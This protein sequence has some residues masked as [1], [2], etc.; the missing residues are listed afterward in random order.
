[1]RSILVIIAFLCLLAACT[2]TNE[3]VILLQAK[4][5]ELCTKD[6]ISFRDHIAPLVSQ[7]CMP[8]HSA[9]R[10]EGGI[11]L[12]NYSEISGLASSGVLM[13]VIKHDPGFAAMPKNEPKIP[14]CEIRAFQVWVDQGT[15]NN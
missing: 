6:T 8:C 4:Q 1:M 7:R 12:E 9:A 13:G 14:E 3:Q 15:L 11:I 2:K 10:M 5:Q